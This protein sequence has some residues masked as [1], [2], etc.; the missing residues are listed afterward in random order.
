MTVFDVYN[1][2]NIITIIF[3]GIHEYMF[4]RYSVY[5]SKNKI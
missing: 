4:T 2:K 1:F 3:N 5:P